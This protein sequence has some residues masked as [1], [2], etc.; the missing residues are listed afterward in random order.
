MRAAAIPE[1]A[2]ALQP[3]GTGEVRIR[4]VLAAVH[5]AG[6]AAGVVDALGEGVR[7][8]EPGDRVWMWGEA[9]GI[10]GEY[11]VLPRS[12]VVRMRDGVPFEVG[13]VLAVPALTAYRRLTTAAGVPDR[14]APGVLKGR[15]VLIADGAGPAGIA[16]IQLAEWAG[17]TVLTTTGAQEEDAAD[18]APGPD[19]VAAVAEAVDAGALRVGEDAGLPIRRFP[20]ERIAEAREAAG[21]HAA[22]AVVIEVTKP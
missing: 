7:G 14:L 4:V 2:S 13:A 21:D 9:E 3:A 20:P 22:G 10:V 12:R 11:P 15:T 17:A 1:S 18:P 6:A 16:A 8:L 5:P 19:A